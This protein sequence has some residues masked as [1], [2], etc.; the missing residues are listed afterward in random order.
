MRLQWP[1]SEAPFALCL[2]AP[3]TAP[4]SKWLSATKSLLAPTTKLQSHSYTSQFSQATSH[5]EGS[6]GHASLFGGQRGGGVTSDHV[7]SSVTMASTLR[8]GGGVA[9]SIATLS[10][11]PQ[12][13]TDVRQLQSLLQELMMTYSIGGVCEPLSQECVSHS[14]TNHWVWY[15]NE[16]I[17]NVVICTHTVYWYVWWQVVQIKIECHC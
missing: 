1:G 7:T 5:I 9:R 12:H 13:T 11:V 8:D 16:T 4:Q 3:L 15:G 17:C 2:Q 14:E 10:D 6:L